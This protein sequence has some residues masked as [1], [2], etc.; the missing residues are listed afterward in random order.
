MLVCSC[1][2]L[3][4]MRFWGHNA[5][6]KCVAVATKMLV[7]CLNGKQIALWV[8]PVFSALFLVQG[9][10]RKRLFNRP[11]TPHRKY[12]LA[13]IGEGRTVGSYQII[14]YERYVWNL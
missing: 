1:A 6:L 4:A 2:V 14:G 10:Y 8:S 5:V 13:H 3:P 9:V 12:E 11:S 7:E